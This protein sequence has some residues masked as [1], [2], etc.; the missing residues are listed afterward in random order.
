[1]R[2]V[3]HRPLL[4]FIVR[5]EN[6]ALSPWPVREQVIGGRAM[7]N[8]VSLPVAAHHALVI[9]PAFL[10]ETIRLKNRKNILI[11]K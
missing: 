10:C 6:G 2:R 8:P 1:M 11:L 7:A 3:R 4:C 5:Q 9:S